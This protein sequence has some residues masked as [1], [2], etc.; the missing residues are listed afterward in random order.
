MLKE[1]NNP[2]ERLTAFNTENEFN[3]DFY[4]K[5]VEPF[6]AVRIINLIDF[7]SDYLKIK[8]EINRDVVN[9]IIGQKNWG[10]RM[11]GA[12]FCAIEN[13]TEFEDIIGIHFLKSELVHQGKGFSLALASFSSDQS[14]LYL[15][16]YLDYYLTRKDLFY[17][18]NYAMSA[19]KWIDEKNKSEHSKEFEKRYFEWEGDSLRKF[20]SYYDEFI[21]Q[22][23]IIEELKTAGNN[24][25]N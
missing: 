21:Q 12:F 10:E 22:M 17:E 13:L 23:L 14:I 11:V 25:N 7:K 9:K 16:T 20:D 3:E 2:F 19:L 5:F 15:K 1:N 4:E 18:Q 24:D 8:P 6:Y